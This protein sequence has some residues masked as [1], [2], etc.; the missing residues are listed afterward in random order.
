MLMLPREKIISILES[1]SRQEAEDV[2]AEARAARQRY[3]GKK[4][5]MYGFVYFTTWCRNDCAFCYYRK[6]NEIERYRKDK[7]EVLKL[8]RELAE[9]GVHLI[10]LTMGEDLQFHREDF[11]SVIE[12]IKRI[13]NELGLPVMISPGV[14]NDAL[15]K[16]FVDAGTDWYALYQETHNRKL[17]ESLRIGQSFDERMHAKLFAAEQGM[18]IEEGLMSGIGESYEDIAHSLIRM[19]EIGAGQ[20]RVMSFVPQKGSPMENSETPDRITELKI[21]ALMRIMYPW[22]LIPASLDVDGIAGLEARLNAGGNVVTSIIPPRTGLAG[23]AQNSMDVDDGGRTVE[24]VKKILEAIGLKA[25]S[26]EEYRKYLGELK[27]R[28]QK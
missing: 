27:R 23:V 7:G 6:S 26:T 14:V 10:D 25:A 16:K 8:S 13:K 19:G 17:F 21:I 20:M 24:E 9:S 22:V 18:L 4:I 2:F 28:M 1:D 12:I 3:F 15:I 11:E 5:F